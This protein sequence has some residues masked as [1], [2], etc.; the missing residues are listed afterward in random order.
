MY[1]KSTRN[2]SL[3]VTASEAIAK[4]ISEEGGLF[5][6]ES[7]PSV[8]ERL[9][10]LR[11][12]D[13]ISLAKEILSLYLTDYTKEEIDECAEKAYETSKFSGEQVRLHEVENEDG[14]Y[15]LELWH[16]PTCAFKDMALQLL[17]HLLTKAFKKQADGKKAVIL[18]ATSGDTGK[19][20]L[21]GF[22]DVENTQ[23]IVFY[24][25]NGVSPMQLRQM[26]TQEGENVCV[27]AVKGNFDDCQTQVKRIFTS[28][29]LKKLLAENNMLFS[30]ANSI[31]WGRLLPQI[32]Y[33]FYAYFRFLDRMGVENEEEEINIA[34]PTGN[35]GNILAAYYAK[36]M[37][38]PVNKFICASNSNN[39]LTDFINGGTY[40]K[41]RHFYTTISPS[42]DILVSS[43][44]E[45]L[46]YHLAGNDDKQTAEWMNALNSKGEYTVDAATEERVKENFAAYCCDEKGTS[47]N[48]KDTFENSSYLIDTHTA[49]A[50]KAVKEYREETEDYTPVVIASTA[51]PYKFSKSVLSSISDYENN[52]EFAVVEELSKV[53]GLEVPAALK[54]LKTKPTRF[55]NVC[56]RDSISEFV[57]NTLGIKE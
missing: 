29:E 42:M 55:T 56:D 31:N 20:A 54:A 28:V 45:R 10:E 7:F 24:P 14:V 38:L 35:F 48:I 4:G 11:K 16:G 40:N 12:L 22:K 37:G 57:I 32:V 46:L 50:F 39:V 13:Y 5:V 27:C 43:N 8:K 2:S 9:S 19:A 3:K 51:S 36:M 47:E 21:E 41:L 17:P 30:S 23:I 25:E 15:S 26:N 1:Y 52:D 44:L 34:V 18:V 33:Y 49:V 6:P 53:S